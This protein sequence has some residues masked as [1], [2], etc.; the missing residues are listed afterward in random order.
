MRAV[1][2]ALILVTI[3][4][5]AVACS[6]PDSTASKPEVLGEQV[7]Q[8]TTTTAY[9]P[10]PTTAYIPPTTTTTSYIPPSR[11]MILDELRER[12]PS[13]DIPGTDSLLWDVLESTCGM[14]DASDGDFDMTSLGVQSASAGTF[15]L[16]EGDA[17]VVMAA[18]VMGPCPRWLE[19]GEI[20]SGYEG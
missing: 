1:R 20:W 17:G 14:L 5:V 19:A 16:D 7:E 6:S 11:A 3:A 18:A 2:N 4:F 9:I 12:V 10:P 15:D 8:T 13:L